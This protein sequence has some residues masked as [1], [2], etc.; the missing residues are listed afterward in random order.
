MSEVKGQLLGIL[1]VVVL[2]A[3]L[4]GTVVTIFNSYNTAI[5]SNVE[6]ITSDLGTDPITY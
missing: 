3:T 6:T 4:A 1:L 2:F 5:Q